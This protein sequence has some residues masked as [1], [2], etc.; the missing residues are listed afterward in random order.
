MQRSWRYE[1]DK[2]TFIICEPVERQAG[3]DETKR[4][5]GDV[6]LFVLG[7][8]GGDD[9]RGL[10]VLVGEIEL[11]IAKPEKRRK[12]YGR[13]A[14]RAFLTY[15]YEHIDEIRTMYG[16]NHPLEYL[17]VKIDQDNKA[18]ISLFEC[19]GFRRLEDPPNHFGEVQLRL[20][21]ITDAA[22]KKDDAYPR[23]KPEGY[24]E[25]RYKQEDD[26]F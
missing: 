3:K 20:H 21:G 1:K 22:V 18:S 23:M 9:G 7:E 10:N 17:R 13:A 2:L 24:C 15:I 6:N 25:T 19:L 16:S 12:G 5:L 11:M 14:L 26:V 8:D 4:M